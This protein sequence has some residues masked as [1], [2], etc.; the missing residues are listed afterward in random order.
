MS[1]HARAALGPYPPF[2]TGLVRTSISRVQPAVLIRSRPDPYSHLRKTAAAPVP[3]IASILLNGLRPKTTKEKTMTAGSA[4]PTPTSRSGPALPDD[5]YRWPLTVDVPTAG[6]L[7]G[8]GRDLSMKLAKS[9]EFPVAV[10]RLGS[11]Y[12]VTRA[13]LIAALAPPGSTP[14]L[15]IVNSGSADLGS[16]H[17]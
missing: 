2:N 9:G 12:R 17:G 8:L 3:R 13:A 4:E 11:R 16:H 5:L 10:L 1:T 15:P 14:E 7:F 6:A